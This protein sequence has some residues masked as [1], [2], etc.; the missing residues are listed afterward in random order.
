MAH[1]CVLF[2]VLLVV[3][4]VSKADPGEG[5]AD[6]TRPAIQADLSALAKR[7]A[8]LE[9]KVNEEMPDRIQV[10][11]HARDLALRLCMGHCDDRFTASFAHFPAV[12]AGLFVQQWAEGVR[13]EYQRCC[14]ACL[15]S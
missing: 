7:T 2:F 13:S 10:A 9:R 4:A 6:L 12:A 14:R 11:L 3:A 15:A 5:G 1:T 8:A